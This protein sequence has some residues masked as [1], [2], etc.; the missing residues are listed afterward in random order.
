LVGVLEETDEHER[1]TADGKR[2]KRDK[3]EI[4]KIQKLKIEIKND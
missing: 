4:D 3:A 1:I 2:V